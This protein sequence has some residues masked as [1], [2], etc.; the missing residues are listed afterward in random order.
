MRL[1]NK[2]MFKLGEFK[3]TIFQDAES[4]ELKLLI[5]DICHIVMLCMD[6]LRLSLS[7]EHLFRLGD[8]EPQT[9]ADYFNWM[10][11]YMETCILLELTR[12]SVCNQA[13]QSIRSRHQ[14]FSDAFRITRR[15]GLVDRSMAQ[16]T[17]ALL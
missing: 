11:Q 9:L 1:S 3:K 15:W 4:S 14:L 16:C 12:D 5:S 10:G 8:E 13:I 6:V 2:V 7:T 17:L